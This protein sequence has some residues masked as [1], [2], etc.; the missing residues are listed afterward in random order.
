MKYPSTIFCSTILSVLLMTACNHRRQF[1]THNHLAADV[2][3]LTIISSEAYYNKVLQTLPSPKFVILKENDETMYSTISRVI[4]YAGK[5][6]VLDSWGGRKLVSFDHDGNPVAVYGKLGNGPGEYTIPIDA[7]IDDNYVYI[8]DSPGRSLLIYNHDGS[9]LRTFHVPVF[10]S[11]LCRLDNGNYMFKVEPSDTLKYQLCLTDSN[12]NIISALLPYPAD[13]VGGWHTK[14]AIRKDTQGI[15][16]YESPLDTIYRFDRNG[17]ITNK[18]ALDFDEGSLDPK[19]KMNYL[20]AFETGLLEKGGM[21]LTN[22]PIF[23][24]DGIAFSDLDKKLIGHNVVFNLNTKE[25]GIQE[26]GKHMSAYS[27][28]TPVASS[29]RGQLISYLSPENMEY[30]EDVESLPDSIKAALA[31]GCKVLQ[32]F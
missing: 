11:A 10:A 14:D 32:I 22:T 15:T 20:K 28:I 5:Y 7:D 25:S 6:F 12:L 23:T 30:L 17:M 16:Y 21:Q 4:D 3:A 2:D 18:I 26:Y 8:L 29:C 13:Y 1:D 9:Y 31:D 24:T 19:A 27:L